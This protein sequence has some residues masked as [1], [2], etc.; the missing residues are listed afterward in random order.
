MSSMV[1]TRKSLLNVVM[2]KKP[3][4]LIGFNQKVS[5]REAGLLYTTSLT[6]RSPAAKERPNLLC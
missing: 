2:D 6:I 4:V 3:K 1:N 5:D